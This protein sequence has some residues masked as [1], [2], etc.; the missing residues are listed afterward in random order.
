[1]W[2]IPC[3]LQICSG[4]NIGLHHIGR[5]YSRGRIIHLNELEQAFVIR[6]VIRLTRGE[7]FLKIKLFLH[8]LSSFSLNSVMATISSAQ[9]HLFGGLTIRPKMV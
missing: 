2:P 8:F 7:K 4:R 1:M 6:R 5:F 9:V 3:L